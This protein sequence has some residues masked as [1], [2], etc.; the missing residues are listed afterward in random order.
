M[1]TYTNTRTLKYLTKP[2]R[3]FD[4]LNEIQFNYAQSYNLYY[5]I[6]K[7]V[8]KRNKIVLL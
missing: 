3:S 7:Y 6:T 2:R 4:I 5:N 1:L 8:R